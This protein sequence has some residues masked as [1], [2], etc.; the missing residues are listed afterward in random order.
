MA[1]L[2]P[3]ISRSGK[4]CTS[5]IE[6]TGTRPVM[7][8]GL[9]GARLTPRLCD[10]LALLGER[11]AARIGLRGDQEGRGGDEAQGI[12]EFESVPHPLRRALGIG[13]L[14]QA[15]AV[16]AEALGLRQHPLAIHRAAQAEEGEVQVEIA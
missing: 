16:A 13:G 14:L 9:R 15:L 12:A 10:G 3:A 2:V 5:P 7:T 4:R 1:G 6:I 8:W 11:H